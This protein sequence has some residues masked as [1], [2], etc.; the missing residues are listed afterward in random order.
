MP[1]FPTTVAVTVA[2]VPISAVP[3]A[4]VNV[5]FAVFLQTV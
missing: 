3:A 4:P 5:T 1:E 2:H